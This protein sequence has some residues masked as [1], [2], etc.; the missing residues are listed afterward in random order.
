MRSPLVVFVGLMGGVVLGIVGSFLAWF[1][2]TAVDGSETFDG[3][4]MG[5]G[6]GVIF[7]MIVAAA[8]G[9]VMFLRA[10]KKGGRAWAIVALVFAAL[11]LAVA[12]EAVL[13]PE[14]SIAYWGSASFGDATGVS[15]K[16]AEAMLEEGFASG[17]IQGVAEVGAYLSFA[18]AAL[19][20]LAAIL[21]IVWAKRFR[22][23][24][25][26]PPAP[27]M[28]AMPPMPAT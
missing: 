3:I 18:G 20:T 23:V 2:V 16:Y 25:E 11:V 21:G 14:S 9:I 26:V 28:P 15:Q 27:P 19:A 13:A 1:T 10:R 17:E 5:I 7:F 4:E 8:F 6:G 12:A 22:R 24:A